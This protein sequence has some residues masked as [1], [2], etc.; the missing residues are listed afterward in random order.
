MVKFTPP[1]YG[2]YTYPLWAKFM[3]W[4]LALCSLV[5]IPV[6]MLKRLIQAKGTFI[7]VWLRKCKLAHFNN[8]AFCRDGKA[9]LDQPKTG[10]QQT[11]QLLCDTKPKRLQL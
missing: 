7:Q 4:V 5:P 2:D 6:V 10:V 8:V 9:S 1:S 11:K 3:G